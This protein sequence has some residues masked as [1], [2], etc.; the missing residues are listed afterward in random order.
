MSRSL[1]WFFH[2]D[3]CR[4]GSGCEGG[5]ADRFMVEKGDNLGK[6][7]AQEHGRIF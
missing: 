7:L 3:L 6:N 2:E 1:T 5:G 4:E